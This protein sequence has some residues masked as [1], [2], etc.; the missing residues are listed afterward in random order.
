[1]LTAWMLAIS[2]L[3]YPLLTYLSTPLV[4][5][6][7]DGQWTIVCTLQGERAV[8]IDFDGDRSDGADPCPV[9]KLLQLVATGSVSTAPPVPGHKLLRLS[10]SD[11]PPAY[12][13]R[14]AHFS[15]FP[16]RAPPFA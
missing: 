7:G 14:A 9:L 11:Q 10:L 1:M 16:S 8:F 2:I 4:M 5:S 13:Y 15:V 6:H 3:M 12:H